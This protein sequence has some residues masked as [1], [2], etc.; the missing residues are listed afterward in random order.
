[1][2]MLEGMFINLILLIINKFEVFFKK[3]NINFLIKSLMILFN[4]ISFILNE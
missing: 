1:M 2:I 4:L 3:I